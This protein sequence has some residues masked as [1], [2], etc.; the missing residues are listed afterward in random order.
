MIAYN[1]RYRGPLEY[2]KFV[3]NIL[4]FATE[5]EYI[6]NIELQEAEE[7]TS[8]ISMNNQLTKYLSEISGN[9]SIATKCYSKFLLSM[10]V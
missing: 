5:V 10:E 1:M 3:L 7:Y 9:N 6:K 4:Q 2:D 8:I